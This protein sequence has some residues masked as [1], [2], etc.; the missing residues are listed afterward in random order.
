MKIKNETQL[1]AYLKENFHKHFSHSYHLIGFDIQLFGCISNKIIGLVDIVFVR[2]NTK[3]IVEVKFN[4]TQQSGNFWASLKIL[5]YCANEQLRN[6]RYKNKIKPVI[7]VRKEIVNY[8]FL[9]IL[10]S[11]KIGYITFELN[12]EL[13]FNINL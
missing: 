2:G 12:P 11:L 3:Y 10:R 5:G 4:D 6:F 13:K 7:M 1:V 8:D 9:A